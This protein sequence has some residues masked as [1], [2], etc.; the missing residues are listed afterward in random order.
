VQNYFESPDSKSKKGQNTDVVGDDLVCESRPTE[1]QPHKGS[2][3]LPRQPLLEGVTV[4]LRCHLRH[5]VRVFST[6]LELLKQ[7]DPPGDHEQRRILIVTA[8]QKSDD[9]AI[10]RADRNQPQ[11]HH[12]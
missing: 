12:H 3:C 8:A 11:E 6:G 10:L 2:I 7:G 4:Q 5:F 9:R 1:P